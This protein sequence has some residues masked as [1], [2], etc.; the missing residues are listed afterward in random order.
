MAPFNFA[1]T[2]EFNVGQ[3]SLGYIRELIGLRGATLGL[4]AMGTLNVVPSLLNSVY[5]SRT[6]VGGLVF[7]R[8][9]PGGIGMKGMSPRQPMGHMTDEKMDDAAQG[10]PR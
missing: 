6:P 5:G 7:L 2:Q 4:G 10:Q 3:V 9:R 8:V 1:A